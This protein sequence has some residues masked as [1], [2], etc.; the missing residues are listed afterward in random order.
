MEEQAIEKI[1]KCLFDLQGKMVRINQRGFIYSQFIIEN[2]IYKIQ[3]DILNLRDN[4]K[5][6]YISVNLNQVYK[7]ELGKH[8][9][10]LFMDN[11][12]ELKISIEKAT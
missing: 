1:E 10:M 8:I 4:K 12:T 11:D 9:L 2:L 6:I 3:N 5:D 7:M